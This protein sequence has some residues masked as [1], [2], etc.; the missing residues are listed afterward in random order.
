MIQFPV[1]KG[2]DKIKDFH[3]FHL[4]NILTV[5]TQIEMENIQIPASKKCEYIK[6]MLLFLEL[7][8]KSV[9]YIIGKVFLTLF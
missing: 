3:S 5:A 8:N 4:Y 6:Y 2:E 7:M 9:S 1:F